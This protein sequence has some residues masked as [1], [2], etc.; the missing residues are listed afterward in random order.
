MQE[1]ITCIEFDNFKEYVKFLSDND[2]SNE[3]A[4]I[5]DSDKYEVVFTASTISKIATA[6][7]MCDTEFGACLVVEND[8]CKVIV[9][10]MFIPAHTHRS[11][12]N[13]SVNSN[14]MVMIPICAKHFGTTDYSGDGKSNAKN[15]HNLFNL[16]GH[17]KR[18]V[19]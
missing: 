6:L 10:D 11:M 18:D 3:V 4:T 2:C 19:P 12:V 7:L 16:Q 1:K 9:K 8:G 14:P 13:F 5:T 17:H 15:L